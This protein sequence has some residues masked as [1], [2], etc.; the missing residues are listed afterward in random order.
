MSSAIVVVCE[1][2][3]GGMYGANRPGLK[4]AWSL[5]MSLQCNPEEFGN[6]DNVLL[7][8]TLGAVG[9]VE[10]IGFV[11]WFDARGRW[12]HGLFRASGKAS[13]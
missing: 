7:N 9:A 3:L 13:C 8:W 4:D 12:H 5:S 11:V 2:W 10:G 6:W 1:V